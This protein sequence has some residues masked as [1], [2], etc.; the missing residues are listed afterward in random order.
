MI[1]KEIFIGFMA[2]IITNVI[3][4]SICILVVSLIKGMSFM[5]T[6]DFYIASGTSWSIL[7]LGAL[8]NLGVF[9]LFLNKDKFYRARGVLLATFI[10][11]ITA[12][13]VYFT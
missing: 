6:Y 1:K 13:I 7:T 10:T 9:F 8:P 5:E 3:G 4:V 12:Y 2:G 11:A